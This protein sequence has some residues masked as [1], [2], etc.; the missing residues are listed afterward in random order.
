MKFYAVKEGRNKGIYTTWDECKEQVHGYKDAKFKKF[1]TKEEALEFIGEGK[2]KEEIPND[3]LVA[4]V[5][6]SFNKKNGS[7]SYGAVL[8]SSDDKKEF[9]KRFKKDEFSKHRNVIG[10]I[11][12]AM[13]AMEYGVEH[14]YKK[15]K[16]HYDYAG[17][18]HWAKGTWKRNKEATK[19]Y[20]EFYN[21]IK[22]KI[23]VE[24]IK[25][26]AH[27]GDKYNELADKLAKEAVIK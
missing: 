1:N 20:H 12:G 4:Y 27:S 23:S 26:K 10:E 14:G 15:L 9:S 19:R 3:L 7:Y 16:L 24:F 2:E 21:S 11:K 17:I 25:V 13:F 8:I 22:E 5:D 6:G 18:M